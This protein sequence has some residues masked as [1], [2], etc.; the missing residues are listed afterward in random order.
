MLNGCRGGDFETTQFEEKVCSAKPSIFYSA[1]RRPQQNLFIISNIHH[2]AISARQSTAASSL[3]SHKKS[4]GSPSET[5]LLC[6]RIFRN[7]Q[8]QG[9]R[10]LRK[11]CPPGGFWWFLVYIQILT[12]TFKNEAKNSYCYQV[13]EFFIRSMRNCVASRP[14]II[15]KTFWQELSV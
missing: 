11:T 13:D 9:C 14:F 8:K 5:R 3:Y 12:F 6:F 10:G 15:I 7:L 2:L 4:R 1:L